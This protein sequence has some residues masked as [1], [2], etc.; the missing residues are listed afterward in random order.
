MLCRPVR[1]DRL[2]RRARLN[3]PTI[4][5]A[6]V[7]TIFA[8][9][10]FITTTA[11]TIEPKTTFALNAN[12]VFL[13]RDHQH[14]FLSKAADALQYFRYCHSIA[15]GGTLIDQRTDLLAFD[16]NHRLKTL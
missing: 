16:K 3:R 1:P 4:P 8:P 15:L 12:V 5:A 9:I 14:I 6:A 2:V 13:T 7:K 11:I 10:L